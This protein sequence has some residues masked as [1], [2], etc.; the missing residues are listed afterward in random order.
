M[1]TIGLTGSKGG[2][3]KEI[4]QFW[5]G[6]PSDDT[7]GSRSHT[8]FWDILFVKWSKNESLILDFERNNHFGWWQRKSNPTHSP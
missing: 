2:H 7:P 1:I 4:C 8:Y 5:I 3:L 6:V